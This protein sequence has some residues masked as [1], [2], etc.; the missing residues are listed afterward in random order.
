MRKWNMP[1]ASR[2]RGSVLLIKL[3]IIDDCRRASSRIATAGARRR[4]TL[5]CDLVNLWN[6]CAIEE[7][8]AVKKK[9]SAGPDCPED[10]A[11][12]PKAISSGEA[13]N[14]DIIEET[15]RRIPRIVY[16]VL[17]A[18]AAS[19]PVG[20]PKMGGGRAFESSSSVS[21]GEDGSDDDVDSTTDGAGITAVSCGLGGGVKT[22]NDGSLG[23]SVEGDLASADISLS[24]SA[25]LV[26]EACEAVTAATA[27]ILPE[28]SS[29]VG[30]SAPPFPT[31]H[32]RFSL[33]SSGGGGGTGC[34]LGA[35][36]PNWLFPTAA[37]RAVAGSAFR[38]EKAGAGEKGFTPPLWRRGW[39]YDE[40]LP[41]ALALGRNWIE[42][43]EQGPMSEKRAMIVLERRRRKQ[44]FIT[45]C[46]IV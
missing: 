19:R 34:C 18:I 30:S 32:L 40:A 16:S 5:W 42:E 1:V 7:T 24:S 45:D 15:S 44:P 37:L 23:G 20:T 25:S 39:R 9:R 10:S 38:T 36:C 31:S 43:A 2:E 28:D 17:P 3:I 8:V 14:T 4:S 33:L 35:S 46:T 26:V 41:A 21:V 6:T 12:V 11:K 29:S 27:S 22:M 13:T